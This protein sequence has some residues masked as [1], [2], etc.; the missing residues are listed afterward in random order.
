MTI[1]ERFSSQ[2]SVTS[3]IRPLRCGIST[4]DDGSES[5][6]AQTSKTVSVNGLLGSNV[7]FTGFL[8]LVTS[9]RQSAVPIKRYAT[10]AGTCSDSPGDNENSPNSLSAM[11]CP[12]Y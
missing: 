3:R 4:L 6:V 7:S 12:L 2:K 10:P 11:A 1:G 5:L 8:T 9:W